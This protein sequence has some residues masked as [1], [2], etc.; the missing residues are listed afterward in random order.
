MIS[1]CFASPQTPR[2]RLDFTQLVWAGSSETPS[3]LVGC[4]SDP[5]TDAASLLHTCACMYA[6]AANSCTTNDNAWFLMDATPQTVHRRNKPASAAWR[7]IQK[8]QISSTC[9]D[10]QPVLAGERARDTIPES[11]FANAVSSVRAH[12]A[13]HKITGASNVLCAAADFRCFSQNWLP[14]RSR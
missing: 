12:R 7:L 13:E 10:K 9:K 8:V 4:S 2:G 14:R 6:D 5:V 11:F 1:S 3:T